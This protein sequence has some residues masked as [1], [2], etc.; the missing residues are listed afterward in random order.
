LTDIY[1]IRHAEAEGNIYR[2]AHGQFDSS[3]IGRA[4]AQIERLKA[5]FENEKID[6]VY[7]SDLLRTCE[8]ASAI[9]K[10]HD[11][12]LR[13]DNRLREIG[14]GE[15]EDMAWGEIEYLFPE[16]VKLFN[17]DTARWRV[18]GCEDY[19]GVQKRMTACIREIA[20]RHDG[21]AVAV[22][23]HGLA[24]RIFLCG[25]LGL[26]SGDMNNVPYFDNTAVTYLRYDD[27]KFS[28]EYKGDNSHLSLENSTFARQTWWRNE[29]ERVYEN[30]RF[31]PLD[32]GRDSALLE[33]CREEAVRERNENRVFGAETQYAAFLGELPVGLIG[34]DDADI[35]RSPGNDISP[36]RAGWIDYIF[37]KPELRFRN[38]GV[39]LLGQAVSVFRKLNCGKL[40]I[41]IPNGSP[42]LDFFL[43]FE[44]SVTGEDAS[45]CLLEK[46][47]RSRM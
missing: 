37:V 12:P 10:H 18:G 8:T 21:G 35:R 44:F 41:S 27:G 2:R 40:R 24:I 45:F 17:T 42:S 13:T 25:L 1:L 22:F 30:L 23:S 14:M 15:W 34:L 11:L 4:Y 16:M 29:R 9:Y 39:Q 43:R 46:N 31:L 3:V 20:Q 26:E 36:D 6:A 32:E 7:S 33:F 28:I 38:F 19:H 47:I 5:R